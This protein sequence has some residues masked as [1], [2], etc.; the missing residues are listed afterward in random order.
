MTEPLV[1]CSHD[2]MVMADLLS[3]HPRNPNTH[4]QSQ[5]ELLAKIIKRTGWRAPITVSTLSKHIVKGHCR[6]LAAKHLNLE[7]VPVDYQDYETEEDELADLLADNRLAELA[8]IDKQILANGLAF[9]EDA[10]FDLEYAGW[11]ND[12]QG[13]MELPE[14]LDPEEIPDRSERARIVVVCDDQDLD[15]IA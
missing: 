1:H 14:L 9:L 3:P 13:D 10:G 2:A 4:P 8:E 12:A 5:V 7:Q 11:E 15:E 6:L